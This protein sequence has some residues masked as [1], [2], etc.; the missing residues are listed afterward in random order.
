MVRSQTIQPS[1]KGRVAPP[2]PHRSE[3]LQENFLNGVFRVVRLTQ[4][5]PRKPENLLMM[6]L[7]EKF[8]AVGITR[9]AKLN[10]FVLC[11]PLPL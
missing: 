8:Q 2:L 9:T 10:G 1:R 5:A 11:H 7:K 4:H 6:Q 3:N